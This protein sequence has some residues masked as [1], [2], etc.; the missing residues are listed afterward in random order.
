MDLGGESL[1]EPMPHLVG[2]RPNVVARQ[3]PS[4]VPPAAARRLP[5]AAHAPAAEASEQNPGNMASVC[6]EGSAGCRGRYP[7]AMPMRPS[8]G[9][10]TRL[11]LPGTALQ[12]ERERTLPTAACRCLPP[13]PGAGC[14]PPALRPSGRPP[15]ALR[16]TARLPTPPCAAHLPPSEEMEAW[17][18]GGCLANIAHIFVFVS[19]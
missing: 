13:P 6:R 17:Q 15:P 1:R 4:P 2:A 7:E 16:P 5:P 18:G 8:C 14:W 10:G 11:D 3:P 12:R 9:I 19:C